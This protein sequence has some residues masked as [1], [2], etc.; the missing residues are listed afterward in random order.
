[1]SHQVRPDEGHE[2]ALLD[3]RAHAHKVGRERTITIPERRFAPYP[4]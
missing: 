2:G 1:M 4:L 3:K